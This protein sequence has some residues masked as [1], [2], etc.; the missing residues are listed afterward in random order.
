MSSNV[1]EPLPWFMLTVV[2]QHLE[3]ALIAVGRTQEAYEAD[4]PE[5][6][7]YALR[8]SRKHLKEALYAHNQYLEATNGKA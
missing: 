5:V 2:S 6:E 3:A 8:D 1:A 4:K 7:Y